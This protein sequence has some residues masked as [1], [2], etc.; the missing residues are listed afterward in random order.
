MLSGYGLIFRELL[1]HILFSEI[2]ASQI[3]N[4]FDNREEATLPY[5]YATVGVITNSL[6]YTIILVGDNTNKG[7]VF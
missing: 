5:Y 1:C 7:K 3:E 2:L 6:Y 4:I